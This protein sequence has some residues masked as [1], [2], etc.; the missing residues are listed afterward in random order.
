MLYFYY[1]LTFNGLKFVLPIL[2]STLYR[3]SR[4]FGG[5]YTYSQYNYT[6]KLRTKFLVNDAHFI[7]I[8]PTSINK[9]TKDLSLDLLNFPHYFLRQKQFAKIFL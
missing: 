6:V 4:I 1:C 7:K 5:H 9:I 2:L 3:A 8:F